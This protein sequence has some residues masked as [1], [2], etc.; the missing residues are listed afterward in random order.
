[1]SSAKDATAHLRKGQMCL[2]SYDWHRLQGKRASSAWGR[3]RAVP[4]LN[5]RG[6]KRGGGVQEGDIL[7]HRHDPDRMPDSISSLTHQPG[8]KSRTK[9][10][11]KKN[12][13]KSFVR[14]PSDADPMHL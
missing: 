12:R 4:E 1:M 7:S 3:F 9:E 5:T 6:M 11:Q 2:R 14:K 10:G 8:R 13:P